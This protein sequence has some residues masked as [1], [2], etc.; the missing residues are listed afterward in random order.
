VISIAFN[1]EE[2]LE[3]I[4]EEIKA[5]EDKLGEKLRCCRKVL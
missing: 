1:K 4:E 3:G 2:H 5:I